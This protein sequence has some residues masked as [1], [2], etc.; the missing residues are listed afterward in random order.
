MSTE[1]QEMALRA[2][3]KADAAMSYDPIL[4]E[5]EVPGAIDAVREA[6][7]AAGYEEVKDV[8]QVKAVPP[9]IF[10]ISCSIAIRAIKAIIRKLHHED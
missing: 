3:F 5:M 7:K 1:W 6:I 10:G 4:M 2:L 9:G 8:W